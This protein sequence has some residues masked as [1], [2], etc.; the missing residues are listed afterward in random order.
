MA[1]VTPKECIS[2]AGQ[3]KKKHKTPYPILIHPLDGNIELGV[4]DERLLMKCGDIIALDG[5]VQHDLTAI[6]DS[7]IRLT[8]SKLDKVE[9]LKGAVES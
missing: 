6:E 8:L 9:R 1:W 4:Q 5:D 3:I 7:V 2:I